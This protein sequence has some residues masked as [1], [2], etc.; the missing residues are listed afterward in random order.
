[1]FP[2]AALNLDE[3]ERLARERL[4]T[5]AYD[6]YASGARDERTLG[7]N[8]AAWARIPLYHRVLVDV[9]HHHDIIA[10]LNAVAAVRA[11]KAGFFH[12]K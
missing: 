11:C 5:M 2:G 4:S 7:E 12:S 10:G 1:M 6:Y 3:L 8:V 9:R